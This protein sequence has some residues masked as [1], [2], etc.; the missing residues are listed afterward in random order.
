MASCAALLAAS[1]L[2]LATAEAQ[3]AQETAR[4]GYLTPTA[5]PPR[6]ALFR[7]ELAKLGWVEGRNI[8]IEYR[9]ANGSFER[10]PALADELVRLRPGVIVAFVTEASVAAKGATKSIPI[11]I[12]GVGDPLGSKLVESLA[13]PG[14]NVTG[15]SLASA[16]IIGKQLELLRELKSG[17]AQIA[18]LWNPANR[19]WSALQLEEVKAAAAKL[20]I[21]LALVEARRPEELEEAFRTT[22]GTR[23]DALLI[24]A[25]PM[26]GQRPNSERIA[27]LA[28][29]HRLPTVA[30]FP[31]YS[32]AGALVAYGADFDEMMRRAAVYVDRILK[33]AKPADLPIERPTRYA[34]VVNLKTAKALGIT[35]PP[36]LVARADRV[37]Q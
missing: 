27:R 31:A 28:I 18:V 2:P 4:I 6:E 23:A 11:V 17:L 12:V 21:G 29:E 19:T 25:D 5:Q 34:L 36:A 16:D 3:P 14:G 33:G 1:L 24:L 13:R 30:P 15:N 37:I 22:K 20:G 35:L 32:E 10:L 26:F 9:N 8:A 7:K